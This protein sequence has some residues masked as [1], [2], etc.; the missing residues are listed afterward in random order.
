MGVYGCEEG[1]RLVKKLNQKFIHRIEEHF[2]IKANKQTK[3]QNLK[4]QSFKVTGNCSKA[5]Q[6]MEK[7]SFRK[8]Y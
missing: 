8:T 7:H 4:I 1:Q 2:L 5:I 3:T 6:Q